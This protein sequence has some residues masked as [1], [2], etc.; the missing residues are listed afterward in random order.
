MKKLSAVRYN[1]DCLLAACKVMNT[2]KYIHD[3]LFTNCSLN[4][5]QLYD[6]IHQNVG[7]DKNVILNFLSHTAEQIKESIIL[8][9]AL[10]QLLVIRI[11]FSTYL[12]D[13]NSP[14]HAVPLIMSTKESTMS[15][16]PCH[17]GCI[18]W[19]FLNKHMRL[20]IKL[21]LKL[22]ANNKGHL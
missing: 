13:R 22:N 6:K 20:L 21:D 17:H 11:K 12:I 4:K 18:Q 15:S 19:I 9:V 2:Y 14:I 16:N 8:H 7:F 3:R 10:F 1:D 5:H